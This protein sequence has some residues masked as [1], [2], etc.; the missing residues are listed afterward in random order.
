MR[1]IAETACGARL[2]SSYWAPP[3]PGQG[4][5]LVRSKDFLTGLLIGSRKLSLVYAYGTLSSIFTVQAK[6][7]SPLPC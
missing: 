7:P 2:P 5:R 6:R 1:H 3:T 4:V